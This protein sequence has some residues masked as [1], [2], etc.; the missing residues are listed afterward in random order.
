MQEPYVFVRVGKRKYVREH[1]LVM[2]KKLGH[3][4][5][6]GYHVHHINGDTRDNRPENLELY[7]AGDHCRLHFKERRMR[8]EF[9][10]SEEKAEKARLNARAYRAAHRE[11]VRLKQKERYYQNRD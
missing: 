2:E 1:I 7:V 10:T 9:L 5:P 3:P 8:G 4:I 11:E 6:K